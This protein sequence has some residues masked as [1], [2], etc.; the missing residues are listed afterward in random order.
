MRTL[1]KFLARIYPPA[2]RARYGEEFDAMLD[3][4]EPRF[5]HLIDITKGA[6]A[7]QFGEWSYVR[8]AIVFAAVGLVAGGL[9]QFALQDSWRSRVTLK[10]PSAEKAN[11][12]KEVLWSRPVMA[13]V[14]M[15]TGIYPG[16]RQTT[17]LE[18][19]VQQ[20][21]RDLR[22]EQVSPTEYVYSFR[23]RTG[24]GAKSTA[25][26]LAVHAMD[27]RFGASMMEAPDSRHIPPAR[28]LLLG[29]AT[30]SGILLGLG[31]AAWAHRY[32]RP[33]HS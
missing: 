5:E 17:P 7:M 2:W 29:I 4:I 12:A 16:E 32:Q 23:Y 25:A 9:G 26:Y 15:R 13:E 3:Q 8:W 20:M 33:N 18:D 11:L 30:L 10:F 31:V 28:F 19:V 6:L 24:E 27:E 1:Q 14:M 22:V 21:H